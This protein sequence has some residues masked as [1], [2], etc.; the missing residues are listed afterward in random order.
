MGATT[1][2]RT[3]DWTYREHSD[4]IFGAVKGRS[5]WIRLADVDDDV[6]LKTGFD[7]AEGEHVQAWAESEGG[8][9]TADQVGPIFYF[10]L[11]SFSFGVALLWC[12]FLFVLF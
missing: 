4:R 10:I 12:V 3:L 9:W 5:R 7:D 11:S 1:E 2:K 8:G 6:F